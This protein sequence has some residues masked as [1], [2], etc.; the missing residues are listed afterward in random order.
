MSPCAA[1]RM[2]FLLQNSV[3]A[4]WGHLRTP[5]PK[6]TAYWIYTQWNQPLFLKHDSFAQVAGYN[7]VSAH[8]YTLYL[9][10]AVS[11]KPPDPSV[12]PKSLS[13]TSFISWG[14]LNAFCYQGIHQ[15]Y[16]RPSESSN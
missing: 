7:G 1:L 4:A 9:E 13:Q 10:H 2:S 12:E 3:Q 6:V 15:G 11:H 16:L 5:I 8:S 14:N